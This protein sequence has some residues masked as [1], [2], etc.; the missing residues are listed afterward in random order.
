MSMYTFQMKKISSFSYSDFEYSN[1]I[2]V[3]CIYDKKIG[4]QIQ[5]VNLIIIY[6]V[7]GTNK[8]IFQHSYYH[9]RPN[10]KHTQNRKD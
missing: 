2:N 5:T 3:Y 4:I 9:R 7:I 10:D 6:F 8:I 1:Q